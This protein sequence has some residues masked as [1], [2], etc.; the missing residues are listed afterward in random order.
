MIVVNH[1]GPTVQQAAAAGD[2]SAMAALLQAGADVNARNDTGDTPLIVAAHEADCA[3]VRLLLDHRTDVTAMGEREMTA[4]Q[5]AE[6]FGFAA[7]VDLL[8]PP[9]SSAVEP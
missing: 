3:M 7:V 1:D 6:E 9:Q 2:V 8:A 5:I 4:L